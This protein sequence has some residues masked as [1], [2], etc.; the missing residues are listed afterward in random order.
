MASS[1]VF[2]SMS[3]NETDTNE[4]TLKFIKFMNGFWDEY[5]TD[6]NGT[7]EKAEFRKFLEDTYAEEE[8]EDAMMK[9]K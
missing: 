1:I 5:D 7:L 8:E 2:T 9:S 4:A 3:N 6:R